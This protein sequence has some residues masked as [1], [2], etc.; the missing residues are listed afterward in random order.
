MLVIHNLDM[1]PATGN[2]N[3]KY[4]AVMQYFGEQGRCFLQ[5]VKEFY[6]LSTEKRIVYIRFWTKKA[7]YAA[8]TKFK[9]FKTLNPGIQFN[10]ARPNVEKFEQRR[11]QAAAL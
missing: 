9:D 11:D 8:E 5:G 6:A 4:N 7:K 1:M 10:V 3:V 2:F